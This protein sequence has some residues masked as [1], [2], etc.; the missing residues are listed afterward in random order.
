MP[1]VN[2]AIKVSSEP[3]EEEKGKTLQEF[4]QS[5]TGGHL[6]MNRTFQRI[7]LYTSWP[8]MKQEIENYVRHCE[9][10]QK[11][12]IT[13]RKN[14]LPLQIT[15]T[16]E[17]VWQNCS[18]DIG[19]PLTLT[20]ENN[21]YLLTF[22]DELSKYTVAAPIQQQDA[23]TVARVFVREIVLKF[24]IPQIMLT[25]QGSNFLSDLF[26]NVCKLLRIKRIK[27]SPFH[28]QTNGALERS[29]RVLVE[30]L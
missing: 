29:H 1:E 25:D 22:Q 30:Y 10:C 21:R 20:S 28:P 5:P 2:T 19:G 6:G 26:S 16:P 9:T 11:N 15:D 3:T 17:V 27:T 24:G 8:G 14:K 4:H 23:M 18:L 13:Q 12:K 7:K